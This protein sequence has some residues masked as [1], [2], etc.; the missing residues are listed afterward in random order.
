MFFV[1]FGMMC[2]AVLI[3]NRRGGGIT[4]GFSP[5]SF[6]LCHFLSPGQVGGDGFRVLLK[7]VVLA[8]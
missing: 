6:G 2:S 5:L 8:A 7:S 3:D 4:M 1:R